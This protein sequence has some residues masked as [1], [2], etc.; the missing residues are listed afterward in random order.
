MRTPSSITPTVSI[1]GGLILGEAA[2]SSNLLSPG[3]IVAVAMAAVA[4]LTVSNRELS[5]ALW[6]CQIFNTILCSIWG[7]FGAAVC[8]MLVLHHLCSLENLGLPYLSPFTGGQ[9]RSYKDSIVK[10]PSFA[11][12][13]R[14]EQF[15]PKNKRRR[16]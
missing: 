5:N 16:G 10:Y 11:M 1:V 8:I 4:S 15:H 14:P 2:I 3:V 13:Y 12:F 6:L 9:K 7:L